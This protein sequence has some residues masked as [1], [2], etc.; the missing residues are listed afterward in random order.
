MASPSIFSSQTKSVS[1]GICRASRSAQ[2][3]SSSGL[4]TLS[5]LI[6]GT[7]WR[8]GEN[9]TEGAAP[10]VEVGESGTTRSGWSASI[11]RSSRTR[12][13]KS[14]S[15]ISGSSSRWY[16]SLWYAIWARSSSA[17]AT[18]SA[19]SGPVGGRGPA[20]LNL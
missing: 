9:R 12:A 7:R 13:S 19:P 4:K 2:P 6:M 3:F 5:R 14:A 1:S 20:G 15:V 11:D 8:T 17:R 10:T 16:R 18:G